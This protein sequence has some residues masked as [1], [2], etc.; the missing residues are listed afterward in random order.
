VVAAFLDLQKA[1]DT[2]WHDGLLYKLFKRGLRGRIVCWFQ[3]FLKDRSYVVCVLDKL[4]K[5][6]FTSAGVPQG[7]VLSALLFI[8][9]VN[10]LVDIIPR[11]ISVAL[12]AD[13]ITLWVQC[14]SRIVGLAEITSALRALRK[15]SRKWHLTFS[16]SKSSYTIFTRRRRIPDSIDSP[17]FGNTKLLLNE[18]PRLLGLVLDKGLYWGPHIDSTLHAANRRLSI[19]KVFAGVTYASRHSLRTLYLAFIRPKLEYAS[20][21]WTAAKQYRLS[22][23]ERFQNTCLRIITGAAPSTP[24]T[25]LQAELNIPPLKTLWDQ[26][27]L[28]SIFRLLR[29]STADTVTHLRPYTQTR[30]YYSAYARASHTLD[31]LYRHSAPPN[32]PTPPRAP[33]PDQPPMSQ[34]NQKL[35]KHYRALF[36]DISKRLI[37]EWHTRYANSILGNAYHSLRPNVL[38]AWPH[39]SLPTY[40]LSKTIFRLRTQRL[41]AHRF[42]RRGQPPLPCPYCGA[43]DTVA[44]LLLHCPQFSADRTILFHTLQNITNSRIPNPPTLRHMLGLPT[45]LRLS[46][47]CLIKIAERVA[48][49]AFQQRPYL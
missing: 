34:A 35:P 25:V 26:S 22:R 36:D 2:V 46:K 44:H 6:Y 8:I 18:H 39:S 32:C 27:L 12:F 11:G 29:L 37:R 7:S 43:D 14:S 24:I 3:S 40:R 21:C 23:L 28:R 48:Q 20:A 33:L 16:A 15:W 10:D 1:Y 17:K 41:G 13:D 49:F 19:L 30:A 9:Y 4:S 31:R 42:D 38:P 5:A 45:E 47:P